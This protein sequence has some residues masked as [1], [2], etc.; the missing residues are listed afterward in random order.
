MKNKELFTLN[1]AENNLKNEGVAKIKNFFESSKEDND[2]VEYELKTFVCE[3]EYH[4]GLKKILETYIDNLKSGKTDVPA[5]W[6]SGF[7]GSGKSHLVKMASYLWDDFQFSN[8]KTAR[9]IKALPEDI[10]DLFHEIDRLQKKHGKLS[11]A[12][13]LRD[14]KSKDINYIL[15]QIFLDAFNLPVLYNH[16]KFVLWLKKENI[17]D[18]VIEIVKSQERNFEN[19]LGNLYMSE[20]IAKAILQLRPDLSENV[21]TLLSKFENTFPVVLTFGRKELIH[22]L[23]NELFPLYYGE[24]TPCTLIVLDEVQQFIGQ[25]NALSF[26]VGLLAETLCSE[27]DGKILLIGT[28]QNALRDTATLERLLARFR[29]PIQLSNTDIQTVIRKTV[30]EKKPTAISLLKDKL[31]GAAGE[32]SRN[33]QGT[34]FGI[35]PD[36]NDTLVADYPLLPST[37]NFWGKV[38]KNIDVAGTSGQLRNQLRLND[39]SVKTIA[40]SEMGRIVPADFIFTQNRSDIIQ[41]GLL[42]NDTSNLIQRKKAQGG[43]AE[44]EG[45][46]L[47]V[48][49][50]LDLITANDPDTGIKANENTIADLLIDN[51]N[52]NSEAFRNKVHELIHKLRDEKVLMPIGNEY[53]LQ[54]KIGAQWEQEYSKQY[55]KLNGS[56]DDQIQNLR[57]EKIIAFFKEKTKTINITQGVSKTVRDFDLWDKDTIPNTEHKLNL[58]IRDGWFENEGSVLEEIKAAGVNTPLSYVFV[59]KLRDAELK[60]EILKYLAADFTI[61]AMGSP[62]T[63]EGQ[64]AKKSM[65]TR[66]TQAKTAIDDFIE[67]ICADAYVYLSGGN[68]VQSGNLRDNIQEALASIADRQFPEF[69]NKADKPSWGQALNRAVAGNPDALKSIGYDG[70]ADK[71]P[72]GSAILNY[73][74]NTQKTGKDIR[75]HF[76]KAPFG[77]PQDA[78]DALLFMLKNTTWISSSEANLQPGKINGANFKKEKIVFTAK[79][80]IAIRK[81]FQDAGINCP[82]SHEIFPF[83]NEYLTKLKSLAEQVSG[84]A[85]RPEPVNMAFIK[86]IEN[87]EGNERLLDILQQKDDLQKKLTEWTKQ[88]EIVEKREPKW[89]ILVELVNHA[90]DKPDLD[91]IKKEIAA[92]KSNRM[93]LQEPDPIEPILNKMTEILGGLLNTKRDKYNEIWAYKM[94]ELQKNEYF[95]KLTPEQKRQILIKQ[96]I[97]AKKEKTST[98]SQA[99]LNH[100]DKVSFYNWDTSIAALPGQFQAALDDAIE[101]SAPQAKTFSLPRATINN[102]GDVEKYLAQLKS[103]LEDLLKEASS[104]ILK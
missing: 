43:D 66:Q 93:L 55:S 8:G 62:T 59:K 73:L 104:I 51:L 44:I 1:P 95:L 40:E 34:K 17:Y 33:L 57:K 65:E 32:I 20:P 39:E 9:T 92:I 101:L 90:P 23:K 15:L 41:A 12:G 58:W 70:D 18:D 50:L 49:F 80:K 3:G 68:L 28:G 102:Q 37:R 81:L 96:Q 91:P 76:M 79:D 46:I 100:L 21:T 103:N 83:S 67:K 26:E 97:L 45:R 75:S 89:H 36:D 35:I 53:K 72:V 24:K 31:E 22:A 63:P 14:F 25:D 56:G 94:D 86:E 29:I 69:K 16:F 71:H 48:V 6:V 52:I 84:D 99:L 64:Q 60:T 11:V 82:G 98:D 19:E 5:Y 54:T 30:L 78:I 61:K 85:P 7:Y 4:D 38:L 10:D 2:I 88:A 47:S 13:T 42:L 87:K 27:F 77:W 74:G